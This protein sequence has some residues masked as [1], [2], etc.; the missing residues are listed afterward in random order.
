[1]KPQGVRSKAV[2]NWFVE[3]GLENDRP[4]D[5]MKLHK[6]LYYAHGWHLTLSNG[7]PLLNEFIEAWDY[8]PVVPSVYHAFKEYGAGPI[9]APTT[10]VRVVGSKLVFPK[11]TIADE[12]DNEEERRDLSEFLKEI[13]ARYGKFS[14]IQL[15]QMTHRPGTPWHATRQQVGSR[16][17]ADISDELIEQYFKKLMVRE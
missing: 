1:M 15:S 8:G 11:P 7:Q 12:T 9:R 16:R 4:V 6:L 13:W 2:A 3:N 17:N 5:H 14:A 10:D